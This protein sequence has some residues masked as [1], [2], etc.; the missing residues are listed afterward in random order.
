MDYLEKE[1]PEVAYIIGDR[2]G[3]VR[4]KSAFKITK[5]IY[6]KVNYAYDILFSK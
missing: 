2:E 3:K 5:D 1:C 6:D 4:Q